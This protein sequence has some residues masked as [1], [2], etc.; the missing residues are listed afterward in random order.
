MTSLSDL[1]SFFP[2]EE[3]DDE[4]EDLF[5]LLELLELFVP[6]NLDLV[7]SFI[8]SNTNFTITYADLS[9]L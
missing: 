7:I 8:L 6:V 2:E 5:D 4:E 3:F 9:L 1:C